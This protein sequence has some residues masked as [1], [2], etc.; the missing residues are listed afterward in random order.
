L[1]LAALIS[2]LFCG[3]AA[4]NTHRLAIVVGHN[5]GT[6]E[7]PL[8]YAEADA[9]KF[10]RVLQEMGGVERENLELLLGRPMKE[11]RQA[12]ERAQKKV[13]GWRATPD[14]RVLVFFYFSGHSD[15][16]ALKLGP[17]GLEFAQL[18]ALLSATGADVQLAIVDTCRSGAL[19]GV[20]GGTPGPSFQIRLDDEDLSS[21]GY[22]FLTSSASDELALE[23]P[24]IRG[25]FFT[26]HLVSGLLGEADVSG[27]RRVSLAEAYEYAYS[28]TVADT[29]RT[30]ISTQHPNYSNQLS[31]RGELVLTELAARSASLV[32]PSGF[33][34]LLVASLPRGQ[35]LAEA[36]GTSPRPLALMPGQYSVRALRGSGTYVAQVTVAQGETRTLRADELKPGPP[37][38][39]N[40]KGLDLYGQLVRLPAVELA[41]AAGARYGVFPGVPAAGLVRVGVRGPRPSGFSVAVEVASGPA[42]AFVETSAVISG[43]YH[44]G[45]QRGRWNLFAG[46]EAGV[47]FAVRNSS[48]GAAWSP[49]VGGAPQ[50]GVAVRLGGRLALSA[51]ADVALYWVRDG[52]A[53]SLAVLPGGRL[54]LWVDL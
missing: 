14:E 8:R 30:T 44:L 17:E 45:L 21:K 18:R 27:D 52:H 49:L 13:A 38:P 46:L 28:R 12:L 23:S 31:G 32:L 36:P 4:A 34:R 15:G 42:P 10:A 41:A 3:V 33:D 20:K 11:L 25:S 51:E 54:G 24:D 37:A 40:R 5:T 50:A 9:A 53:D 39:A 16:R 48:M 26:H 22:V 6:D 43:G 35:V 2:A 1:R 29:A 19:V 7:V 47:G